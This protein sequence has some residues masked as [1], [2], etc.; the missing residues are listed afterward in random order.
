MSDASFQVVVIASFAVMWLILLLLVVANLYRKAGPN[1]ALIVYGYRGAR[2]VRGG[3]LLVMP[4]LEKC[5]RLP[6]GPM[7][8]DVTP[9][10]GWR[11]R[12]DVTLAGEA[13]AEIQVKR[14]PKSILAA[15]E[16]FLSQTPGGRE[17]LIRRLL[18]SP[19][20]EAA[21]RLTAEEIVKE[22]RLAGEIVRVASAGDMTEMGLELNSLSFQE[23]SG[24]NKGDGSDRG[25]TREA[26]RARP[27]LNGTRNG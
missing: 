13:T 15:A 9:E 18:E 8:F 17:R 11:S 24:Q 10:P 14:D 5:Q 23:R 27:A 3:G 26:D 20:R 7:L 6:L 25:A 2:I 22:P 19:L 1:E 21:G 12:D 4:L 16:R